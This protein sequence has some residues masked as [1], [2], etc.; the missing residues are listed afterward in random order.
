MPGTPDCQMMSTGAYDGGAGAEGAAVGGGGGKR[1][2]WSV[3]DDGGASWLP[4]RPHPDLITP[5]CM[6]SL[7]S[8]KEM[9]YFAGP[10]SETTRHN[11]TILG[12]ADNGATFSK[13]LLIW[14]SHAGYTGLQCGLPG[15]ADCAVVFDGNGG[16]CN[17][18]CFARFSSHDLKDF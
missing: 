13:S 11:L 4:P 15:R 2:M 5:V 6:G 14:P 9:V 1:F 12:S 17:G 7:T 3:S 10:Y 8:Y 18:I 16:E